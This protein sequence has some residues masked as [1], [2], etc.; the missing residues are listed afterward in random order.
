MTVSDSAGD[1]FDG[2]ATEEYTVTP[3]T[4]TCWW[5]GSG[6]VQ[7]PGVT[8]PV[9]WAAGAYNGAPGPENEWG[10]DA[11]GWNLTDLDN[12]VE[13]G[14]KNG[15]TFPCIATIHQGMRIECSANLWFNYA[16]HDNT[17]TVDNHG[18]STEEVCRA[19]E[20]GIP[21]GFADRWTPSRIEWARIL[22]PVDSSGSARS[23]PQLTLVKEAR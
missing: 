19:G 2:Q 17:I 11:I 15:V 5:S 14:P 9:N 21:E 6:L 23:S 8:G 1:N 7:N 12:I 18:G 4:N 3:G 13:N 22:N 10:P 16:A 20:C